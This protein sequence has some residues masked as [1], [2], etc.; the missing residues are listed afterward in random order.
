MVVKPSSAAT[1]LI[2]TAPRPS[3]SAIRTAAAPMAVMLRPGF[4][5]GRVGLS[6]PHSSCSTR[7]R[8]PAV[9]FIEPPDLRRPDRPITVYSI[10]KCLLLSACDVHSVRHTQILGGPD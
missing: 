8:S 7:G 1:L 9:S 2:E 4:G 6:S 5:P 3:A 10:D